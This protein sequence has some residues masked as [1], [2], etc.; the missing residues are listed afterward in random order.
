MIFEGGFAIDQWRRALMTVTV[1]IFGGHSKTQKKT[2][3]QNS[4][5]WNHGGFDIVFQYVVEKTSVAFSV[6]KSGFVRRLLN[7]FRRCSS[8]C[9]E[10]IRSISSKLLAFCS[11]SKT[12]VSLS[13]SSDDHFH[14]FHEWM[15]N[16]KLVHQHQC[17]VI[18]DATTVTWFFFQFHCFL[19]PSWPV[20]DRCIRRWDSAEVSNDIEFHISFHLV[21]KNVDDWPTAEPERN[22]AEAAFRSGWFRPRIENDS[23][24]KKTKK[25]FKKKK[26]R[27]TKAPLYTPRSIFFSFR[28]P[29]FVITF[30][31]DF[32]S[33]D[34]NGWVKRPPIGVVWPT[35]WGSPQTTPFRQKGKKNTHHQRN[36]STNESSFCFCCFL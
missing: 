30:V 21:E 2:N 32:G 3:K 26:I 34:P 33:F 20:F 1:R 16:F 35:H 5:N 24:E 19:V 17:D 18:H 15:A 14:R 7:E 36:R 12:W 10:G 9:L 22:S 29:S 28:L 8:P 23:L 13:V 4:N 27:P 25:K 6:S 31:S 11:V